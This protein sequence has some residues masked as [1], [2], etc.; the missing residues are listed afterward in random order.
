MRTELS[1]PD[2]IS[3]KTGP[4]NPVTGRDFC[5]VFDMDGVI[6]DN[7]AFH[8]RAWEMFAHEHGLAFDPE[9]F[10]DHLFG[11]VN[12]DILLGLF[13]GSLNDQDAALYAAEKEALYRRLYKG[14]V[15]PADGL[16]DFLKKLKAAGVM[17]AV[18]TAAPRVNL[19]FVLDEA[20]LRPYFDVLVDI[21]S[22]RKGKPAPDLYLKAAKELG[23]R[24]EECLAFEDSYPGIESALAAG[25]RVV[26]FTTT[27]TSEELGRAHMVIG[28]FRHV[29][30]ETLRRLVSGLKD[31][32]L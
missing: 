30:V 13:K 9:Y 26:G 1:T 10:K 22:V 21:A 28:S 6:V 15:E 11:R 25:M 20:G 7:R 12:H 3:K 19:D 23:R 14:H 31:Q 16:V 29:S 17:T 32:P 5:V 27:H 2:S 4:R 18:A 8:F 24:P